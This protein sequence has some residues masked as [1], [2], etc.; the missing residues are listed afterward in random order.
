M[1][2]LFSDLCRNPHALSAALQ[3]QSKPSASS[4]SPLVSLGKIPLLRPEPTPAPTARRSSN[5]PLLDVQP[6]TGG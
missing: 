2:R 1:N 6:V 3:A 4:K 5:A